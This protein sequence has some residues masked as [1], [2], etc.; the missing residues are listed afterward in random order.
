M[1]QFQSAFYSSFNLDCLKEGIRKRE[2][3]I[4]Q[5]LYDSY[6]PALYTKLLSIIEDPTRTA[7]ILE[8]TFQY[9]ISHIHQHD[10][11]SRLHC[12]LLQIANYKIIEQAAN[13]CVGSALPTEEG[14]ARYSFAWDQLQEGEREILSLKFFK[15]YSPGDIATEWNIPEKIVESRI[16]HALKNLHSLF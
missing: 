15:G 10:S 14:L 9:A 13:D 8:K 16:T 1:R 11:H 3:V 2:P 12:W 4:M 7:S 6:A 5:I